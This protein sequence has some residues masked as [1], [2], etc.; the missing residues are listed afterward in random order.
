M[1]PLGVSAVKL[2][3]KMR[4]GEKKESLARLK[5]GAALLAVGTHALIQEEAVFK[6]LSLVIVDEQHR[7]GAGQRAVLKNKSMEEE[8]LYPIF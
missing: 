3:G 6:N 1:E 8:G 7:F 4:A 2:T 5:S